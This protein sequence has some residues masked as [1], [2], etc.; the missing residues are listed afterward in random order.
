VAGLTVSDVSK[1]RNGFETSGPLSYRYR[2][3]VIIIIIIIIMGSG[4]VRACRGYW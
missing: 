4:F 1:D 2:V 3:I